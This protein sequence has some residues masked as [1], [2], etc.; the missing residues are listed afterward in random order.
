MKCLTKDDLGCLVLYKVIYSNDIVHNG[1]STHCRTVLVVIK[2]PKTQRPVSSPCLIVHHRGFHIQHSTVEIKIP[3]IQRQPLNHAWL[4]M[5]VML[6]P[7]CSSLLP[8]LGFKKYKIIAKKHLFFTEIEKH[9][10]FLPDIE[11]N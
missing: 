2:I 1:V 9:T 6:V 5:T 8:G 3:K 11:H 7:C 4:S 10:V